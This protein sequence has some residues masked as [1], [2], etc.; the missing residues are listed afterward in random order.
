MPEKTRSV[1]ITGTSTGIGRVTALEL[2]RKGFRVFAGVRREAD[3][4]SIRAEASQRLTP[5]LL[6]V[7]DGEAVEQAAKNVAAELGDAGL[8]GL[9][10][11]AGIGVGGP[12]EFVDTDEWRT[13][14]EVNVF[15]PA[16][17]I[18]AFMPQVRQARGRIVNVSSAA[19]RVV[20][21]LLGPYCASK[22]ALEAMSDSLRV[23]VRK[24]GIKV[25]LVEP[26]FIETPMLDKGDETTVEALQKLPPEGREL[27]G[28]SLEAFQKFVSSF[29]GR[30]A[31]PEAV[32]RAIEQALTASSPKTRYT[33][34]LDSKAFT[35]LAWLLPDR[36]L[37]AIGGRLTKL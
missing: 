16:A 26:G 23:E 27:Y 22:F 2:D 34:G 9:V 14:F 36:G 5:L 32:A 28:D 37:D 35:T 11:N 8:D 19:G 24:Q 20:T 17:V 21:P 4:Q 13:Q 18:R 33:V 6:D 10:N 25:S 3:A 15:G 12:L 30:A 7:T 31:K 29:R 1:V